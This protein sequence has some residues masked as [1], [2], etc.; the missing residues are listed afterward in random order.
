M[1]QPAP[2]Q[3]KNG[4]L[5]LTVRGRLGSRFVLAETPNGLAVVDIR[6]A[7]QRI[8][9]EKLLKN[10]ESQK[11]LRQQLLLPVTLNLSQ[12]DARL[13]NSELKQFDAIGFTIEPFGG[14]SFIVTAVPAD[15]PNQD[16]SK[17]LRDILE[18]IR[19]DRSVKSPSALHLAQMA[20]RHAVSVK[21]TPTDEEI[22]RLLRELGAAQMPYADPLGNPTMVHI[23]YTELDKR[24]S[25]GG[26]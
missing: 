25:G 20:C 19:Q 21:D 11:C 14:Q 18:D 5:S 12:M 2:Q 8:L 9:F 7:H 24:F 6:A 10:L 23:T 16:I 22:H 15:Y 1:Q 4:A 26:R 3:S 13:M 17:A